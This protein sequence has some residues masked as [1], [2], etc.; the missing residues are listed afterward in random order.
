MP[1]G[2]YVGA[3]FTWSPDGQEIAYTKSDPY[4][5]NSNKYASNIYIAKMDD[6]STQQRLT[7]N[8]PGLVMRLAWSPNNRYIAFVS[9]QAEQ[10]E[11]PFLLEI[12]SG[13]IIE[14]SANLDCSLHLIWSP[15]SHW[16]LMYCHSYGKPQTPLLLNT[17]DLTARKLLA[18]A[19][20]VSSLTWLP[21]SRHVAFDRRPNEEESLE[22]FVI[23]IA[24]GDLRKFFNLPVYGRTPL[25]SPDGQWILFSSE[26]DEH[27]RLYLMKSEG[28]D[29]Y[30]V[31]DGQQ[32]HWITLD[33]PVWLP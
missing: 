29:I 14:L 9:K 28:G 31:L 6:I 10:P 3:S 12:D 17:S 33:I 15:D 24:T 32:W 11:R 4:G 25:W 23:D 1:D 27:S 5:P 2:G 8:L 22:A 7:Q 20:I 19:L 21:D 18:E 30:R 26:R 16:L 13:H